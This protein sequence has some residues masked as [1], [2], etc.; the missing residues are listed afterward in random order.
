MNIDH[1]LARTEN[2]H[3]KI[4]IKSKTDLLIILVMTFLV[5]IGCRVKGKFGPLLEVQGGKRRTRSVLFGTVVESRPDKTWR[6]YWDNIC[7]TADHSKGHS[8]VA[9]RD[10]SLR[11][12]DLAVLNTPE[13]HLGNAD[14]LR[15]YNSAST[16]RTTTKTTTDDA[17]HDNLSQHHEVA[18]RIIANT[19]SSLAG[20]ATATSI[21]APAGTDS[22]AAPAGRADGT[23]TTT[24]TTTDGTATGAAP[25]G[26][27]SHATPAGTDGTTTDVTATGT[28]VTA[29]TTTIPTGAEDTEQPDDDGENPTYEEH[30][31]DLD[32][33][34]IREEMMFEGNHHAQ[35]RASYLREK[36]AMIVLLLVNSWIPRLGQ[37]VMM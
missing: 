10:P 4:N 2:I 7:R 12:E 14:T 20:T 9:C 5:T 27:T 37:Y 16:S 28:Y 25:A 6:V 17:S 1:F 15:Y 31:H 32:P 3:I 35:Q 21:A 11:D 30:E 19:H 29:T 13:R 18:A 23:T 26:T 36:A 24:T 8:F 33:N 34:W 22:L